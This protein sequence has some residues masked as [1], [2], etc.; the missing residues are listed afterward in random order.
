MPCMFNDCGCCVIVLL[1][2]NAIAVTIQCACVWNFSSLSLPVSIGNCN[3][4]IVMLVMSRRYCV[5]ADACG[6]TWPWVAPECI[7]GQRCSSAADMYSFGVVLWEIV[8]GE[9]PVRG[10]LRDVEE[11]KECPEGFGALITSCW[12]A[13]PA[14]R[15]TAFDMMTKL[16][17]MQRSRPRLS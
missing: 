11:G 9:I 3:M 16:Q 10:M 14:A 5:Y 15:P 2:S 8:T 7:L 1:L 4:A 17:E 13:N 6:G 12:E